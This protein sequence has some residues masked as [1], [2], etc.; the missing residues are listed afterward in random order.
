MAH[1]VLTE[2]GL[3]SNVNTSAPQGIIET[4]ETPSLEITG[5]HEGLSHAYECVSI[6]LVLFL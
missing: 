1:F 4:K 5:S 6:R 3:R 2:E